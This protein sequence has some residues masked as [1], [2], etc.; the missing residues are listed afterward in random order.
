[1]KLDRVHL[2]DDTEDLIWIFRELEEKID[3]LKEENEK[4]QEDSED[5]DF[6]SDSLQE[7]IYGLEE[8]IEGLENQVD[9]LSDRLEDSTSDVYELQVLLDARADQVELL[10]STIV[11]KDERIQ[12]LQARLAGLEK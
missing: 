11:K 2:I 12:E 8:K 9:D 3:E 6:H 7:K 1:M 4:L 10:E 5:Y